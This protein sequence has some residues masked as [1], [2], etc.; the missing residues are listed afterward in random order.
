MAQIKELK[1][2]HFSN[3]SMCHMKLGNVQ[4]ARDNSSKALAIDDRHIKR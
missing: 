2:V 3:L 4:K 1:V